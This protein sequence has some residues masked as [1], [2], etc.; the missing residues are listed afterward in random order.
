[1]ARTAKASIFWGMADPCG[2]P[3][4]AVGAGGSVT[5]FNLTLAKDKTS[6]SFLEVAV[7]KFS[8][9][10]AAAQSPVIIATGVLLSPLQ[11]QRFLALELG[12]IKGA[13]GC[14]LLEE[15]APKEVLPRTPC[16]LTRFP[17]FPKQLV[18]PATAIASAG[19]LGCP[20]RLTLA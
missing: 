2:K 7:S 9:I 6:R 3:L 16:K 19:V 10:L 8:V 20:E 4:S 5:G 18:M 13:E 15:G 17:A 12:D 1:M 11:G 14:W